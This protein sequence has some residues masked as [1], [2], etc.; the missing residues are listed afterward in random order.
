MKQETLE[1]IQI[2][3]QTIGN[4]LY[5]VDVIA[6]ILED[7]LRYQGC[8]IKVCEYATIAKVLNNNIKTTLGYMDKFE[9]FVLTLSSKK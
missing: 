7:I 2:Y 6:R 8:G 9:E 1:S 5:T 3:S 4:S